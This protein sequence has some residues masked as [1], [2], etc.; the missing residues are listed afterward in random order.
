MQPVVGNG[1]RQVDDHGARLG[2]GARSERRGG[3]EVEAFEP[4]AMDR[5]AVDRTLFEPAGG[6]PLWIAVD[7]RR[8]GTAKRIEARKIG[9]ERRLAATP[10]RIQNDN[11][12]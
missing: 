8:S 12:Q 4:N 2:V 5:G 11:L 9:R 10:L 6:E 7:E 3:A 1:R